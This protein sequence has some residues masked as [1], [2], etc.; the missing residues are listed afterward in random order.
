MAETDLDSGPMS[1]ADFAAKHSSGLLMANDA[2]PAREDTAEAEASEEPAESTSDEQEAADVH[3]SGDDADDHSKLEVQEKQQEQSVEDQELELPTGE[4][5]NR[6]EL[7]KGYLRQADYTKKTQEISTE[8]QKY[9]Q[10][11][12]QYEQQTLNRLNEIDQTLREVSQQNDLT[13]EQWSE[14][15]RTNPEAYLL[16]REEMREREAQISAVKQERDLR[17]RQVMLIEQRK[18]V[19]WL[20]QNDSKL[21]ERI[22]EWKDSEA[23]TKLQTQLSEYLLEQGFD[24]AAVHGID[25]ARTV[26]VAYKA[27]KWDQLQ[28]SKPLIT[29]KVAQAPKLVKPGAGAERG[30]STRIA[31]DTARKQLRST[32]SVDAF[33][34]ILRNRYK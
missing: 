29:K 7:I 6:D 30:E 1:V 33:A 14:L 8:R 16:K 22:P 26:E 5:V 27:M 28:K 4:K 13:P 25:D 3:D 19:E 2:Q 17:Q 15:R 34:A 12:L 9:E 24:P 23:K 21:A 10:Q 11:F 31:V 20:E 18:R 32:G